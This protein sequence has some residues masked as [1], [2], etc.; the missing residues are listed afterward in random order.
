MRLRLSL[1]SPALDGR[2][3]GGDETY[4]TKVELLHSRSV[5][6]GPLDDSLDGDDTEL[7]GRLGLERS[8]DGSDRSS[9]AGDDEDFLGGKRGLYG[10]IQVGSERRERWS[11][12]SYEMKREVVS[13]VHGQTLG[14][15]RCRE[16]TTE[17]TVSSP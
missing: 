2:R 12:E 8:V 14:E 15:G 17:S 6:A 3:G 11:E 10:A 4:L 7:D 1:R 5:D 13:S 9:R 16:G